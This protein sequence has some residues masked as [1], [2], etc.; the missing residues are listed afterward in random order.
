MS[1]HDLRWEEDSKVSMPAVGGTAG[2]IRSGPGRKWTLAKLLWV[3]RC[4]GARQTEY[5]RGRCRDRK[6][7]AAIGGSARYRSRGSGANCCRNERCSSV[8]LSL[9]TGAFGLFL[10]AP[11]IRKL[12]A[13]RRMHQNG[14]CMAAM[15]IVQRSKY[16]L[17]SLFRRGSKQFMPQDSRRFHV[18]ASATIADIGIRT[19]RSRRFR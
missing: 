11:L 12:V 9:R 4:C 7:R 17:K 15:R 18:N 14:Y 5:R 3:S 13:S 16:R 2:G 8:C 19:V 6:A 10:S 1:F